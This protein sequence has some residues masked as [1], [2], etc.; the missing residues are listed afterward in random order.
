MEA[1]LE[2]CD[3][4][5]EVSRLR[6]VEQHF[7]VDI[8][9]GV[10]DLGA[11]SLEYL[12]KRRTS[13]GS[14]SRSADKTVLERSKKVIGRIKSGNSEAAEGAR[15]IFYQR[16]A[17]IIANPLIIALTHLSTLPRLPLEPVIRLD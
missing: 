12:C 3:F 4:G 10:C 13:I 7:V 15:R 14:Y 9:S 5:L 17:N 6:R 16:R 8:E 2:L 11:N 1:G